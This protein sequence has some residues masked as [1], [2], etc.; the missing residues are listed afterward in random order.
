MRVRRIVANI[1]AD[2]LD[3]ASGFYGTLF[4]LELVMDHGWIATYAAPTRSAPQISIAIE[5]G[6]NAPFAD[7]SIEV[8]NFDEV[9]DRV[10][11]AGH[12]I[13]YGPVVEPWGVRRFFMR[14]PFGRMINVLEHAP[15]M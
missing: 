10:E 8:D 3:A 13:V 11:A 6:S 1:A 5:A 2:R 7:I 15:A 4:D 9:L 14:D 12:T